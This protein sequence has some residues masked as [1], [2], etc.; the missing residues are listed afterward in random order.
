MAKRIPEINN[1]Q[2]SDIKEVCE[3]NLGNVE[4]LHKLVSL[5]NTERWVVIQAFYKNGSK[6]PPFLSIGRIK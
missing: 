6:K 1:Y 3:L 4:D 5:L 2:L